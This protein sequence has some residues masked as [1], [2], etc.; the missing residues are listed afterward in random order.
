MELSF[1]PAGLLF[2]IAGYSFFFASL[3]TLSNWANDHLHPINPYA[4]LDANLGRKVRIEDPV[5]KG[6]FHNGNLEGIMVVKGNAPKPYKHNYDIIVRVNKNKF[7]ESL[8]ARGKKW[9]FVS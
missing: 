8:Y 3:I 2:L 4:F 7:Y 9:D 6:H 1:S 5:S